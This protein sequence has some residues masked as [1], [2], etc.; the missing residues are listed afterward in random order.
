MLTP[1]A[2]QCSK[3]LATEPRCKSWTAGPDKIILGFQK[4]KQEDEGEYRVEIE[5][6]HGMQE[7]T[8]SLYVT[9]RISCF[10]H[11]HSCYSSCVLFSCWRYGL[12]GYVD[13]EEEAREESGGGE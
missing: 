3:D 9:G 13:E 8:F 11:Y 1:P 4:V 12:Q 2:L 10:I 6:E 5:N 7:H